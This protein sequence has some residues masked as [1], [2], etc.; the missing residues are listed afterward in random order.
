MCYNDLDHWS[1]RKLRRNVSRNCGFNS[2][3]S[4]YWSYSFNDEINRLFWLIFYSN[5]P[6]KTCFLLIYAAVMLYLYYSVSTNIRFSRTF[7][8]CKIYHF[9]LIR[10]VYVFPRESYF[11]RHIDSNI[12]GSDGKLLTI[13]QELRA[14]ERMMSIKKETRSNKPCSSG[15]LIYQ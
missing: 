4:Y 8:W 2:R 9:F 13:A 3:H 1:K 7:I 11:C 14:C 10:K 5:I 15:G 6:S 12:A